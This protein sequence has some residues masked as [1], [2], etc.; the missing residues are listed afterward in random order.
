MQRIESA[1]L[2]EDGKEQMRKTT[3]EI[4]AGSY[5]DCLTAYRAGADRVELNSALSLGGLTPSRGEFLLA[6]KD[7]KIPIVCMVRPRD[8][9]FCYR[10]DEAAVM[11][12]DARFFLE[13]GADGIAFGFLGED[14]TVDEE[15]TRAMCGLAHYYGKE[16]VFHRAFDVT[17]DADTAMRVLIDC[18]ADRVLTSGQ[19]EK[20]MEGISMIVRLEK[21]YG[22]RIE[23]LPGSGLHAGNAAVMLA[24]SGVNQIHA[25]CKGYARDATTEG[26]GVTY[27]CLAPPHEK[28]Y[29]VVDGDAVRGLV[30]AVREYAASQI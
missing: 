30:K 20:A 8:A 4:C 7:C 25:S 17:P 28:E 26:N 2:N 16:A 15:R 5:G 12:E 13:N 23:I 14:G 29:L 18:Q 21:T 22:S 10:E 1:I 24:K 19:Q 6:R 27:A 9:G 11:M 3:V